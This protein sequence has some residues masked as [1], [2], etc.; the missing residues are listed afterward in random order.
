M[1]LK[2]LLIVLPLS[3]SILFW[4]LRG[5]SP[6]LAPPPFQTMQIVVIR[7]PGALLPF[8]SNDPFLILSLIQH[9]KFTGSYIYITY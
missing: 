4:L 5:F 6:N 9:P 1:A 7:S 8:G 2:P 3:L